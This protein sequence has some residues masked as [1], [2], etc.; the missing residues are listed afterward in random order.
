MLTATRARAMIISPGF[1]YEN[2]PHCDVPG[3]MVFIGVTSLKWPLLFRR[4]RFHLGEFAEFSQMGYTWI[5]YDTLAYND[6]TNNAQIL[7]D[8]IDPWQNVRLTG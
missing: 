1:Q 5:Y 7:D 6:T 2:D 4:C 8:I 3:M